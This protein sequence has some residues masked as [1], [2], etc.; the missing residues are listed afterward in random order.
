MLAASDA[1]GGTAETVSCLHILPLKIHNHG[2]K[3]CLWVRKSRSSQ[4]TPGPSASAWT[5]QNQSA[6]SQF[7]IDA[8]LS[9]AADKWLPLSVSESPLSSSAS[10]TAPVDINV[11][12]R[13]LHGDRANVRLTAAPIAE[14]PPVTN[15][16]FRR[17]DGSMYPFASSIPCVL[18]LC[19]FQYVETL[20]CIVTISRS[21]PHR[22]AAS[23]RR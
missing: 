6:I 10:A 16:T 5:S 19:L 8:S 21:T 15:A 2:T 20:S 12:D 17:N 22:A 9:N 4:S 23:A 18:F 11:G 7:S 3:D 14:A 13:N 1:V